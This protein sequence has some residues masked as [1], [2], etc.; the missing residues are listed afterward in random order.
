MIIVVRLGRKSVKLPNNIFIE[1]VSRFWRHLA[2]SKMKITYAIAIAAAL[3]VALSS[4]YIT[5]VLAAKSTTSGVHVQG[6][7]PTI[8]GIGTGSVSSSSFVLAGLGQGTGTAQLT[9]QGTFAITC[10]NPA[11]PPGGNNDVPGQRTT[12]TGSSPIQTI[13]TD[14][15]GKA[16]VGQLTAILDPSTVDTAGICPN[17]QWTANVVP[18]SG[19]IISATLTVTFN[20]LPVFT[21]NA[22]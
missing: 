12:A 3:A 19:I 20:G 22:P 1:L 9:V 15:N 17:P 18:G 4:S 13:S 2:T 8:S 14:K 7:D 10:Q 5:P 16:N 6:A 11:G 21:L